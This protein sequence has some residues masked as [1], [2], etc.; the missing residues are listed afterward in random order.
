MDIIKKLKGNLVV[1][2]QALEGE[3]L[4]VPGYM[5]RM[6]IAAKEGGAVAIRANGSEDIASIKKE[7]D[8]PVIGIWKVT[9]AGCDVFI[10]PTIE[11]ARKIYE[12]GADIIGV[13]ATFRKNPENKWAWEIIKEIKQEMDVLVMADISTLEEGIKAAEEGADI[14]G[15]TLSG[16]TRY[17]KKTNGPDFEL[18]RELAL[19]TEVPIMAEGRITTVEEVKRAFDLGA[20]CVTV[21][22][23]ITRPQEI[24]KS[25]VKGIKEYK[26]VKEN[27]SLSIIEAYKRNVLA[28]VDDSLTSQRDVIISISKELANRIEAGGII[29]LFGTGHSHMLAEEAFYRA[30]GLACMNAILEPN[31]MLHHGADLSGWIERIEG[32]SEQIIKKYK[33][34]KN[35]AMIIISNSGRNPVPIEMAM[36]AKKRG[37]YTVGITS[38]NYIDMESRHSSNKKLYDI[39]DEVLNNYTIVGDAAVDIKKGV[40]MGSI[41]T[42]SGSAL[43]Q[44]IMIETAYQLD[45]RGIDPPV[46]KSVNVGDDIE[47]KNKNMIEQY[48]DRINF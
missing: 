30:G 5:T 21:G 32:L 29:Y 6:A 13:D 31:L 36:E 19:K 9:I 17:S 41:S 45:K 34:N 20:H 10:T 33:I 24:T 22:G 39:V 37:L 44:A 11:A 26:E 48:R 35:D 8:L 2:C 23:G 40:S 25:F 27:K 3:P 47:E 4:H 43:I 15:T 46:I 1:S 14:I 38:L 42:I 18:I 7:I 16:Y 28:S 12:A